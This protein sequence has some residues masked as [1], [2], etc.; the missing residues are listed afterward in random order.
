[1]RL[2]KC[3]A[4]GRII[5][6]TI[7]AVSVLA[8][9]GIAKAGHLHGPFGLGLIIGEP[10]GIGAKLFLGGGN[11]VEGALAWSASGNN[12]FHLQGDYVY[13]WFDLIKVERGQLPV[14]F[15]IGGRIVFREN[16]KDLFGIRFPVGLAYELEQAP[17]DFFFQLVPILDLVPDTDVDFEGAIGARFYFGS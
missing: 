3:G 14:T 4:A 10:T 5:V 8:G 2:N 9:A 16:D 6:A 15:G 7:V 12:E 13:H 1:M 11:A 17:I